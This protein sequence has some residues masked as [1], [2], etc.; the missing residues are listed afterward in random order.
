M[1]ATGAA[2]ELYVDS[3]HGSD[4]AGTGT[5]TKPFRSVAAA[6]GEGAKNSSAESVD[7]ILLR[8]NYTS[9]VFV[10]C[11]PPLHSISMAGGR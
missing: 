4:S 5:A 10:E 7:L 2:P 8:G 9:A 3:V 11:R 1:L 6:L